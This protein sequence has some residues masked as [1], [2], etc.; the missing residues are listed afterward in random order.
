M[1]RPLRLALV[2]DYSL[3]V[4]GLKGMLEG[5]ADRIEVVEMA[6]RENAAENVDIA[7]YDT[8]GA[9]TGAGLDYESLVGNEKVGKVVAY[10]FTHD[11]RAVDDAMGAGADG[12]LSKTLTAQ[13]LVDALER[14]AAG[15][16]VVELGDAES[17]RPSGNWPGEEHGLTAREAEVLGF[18]AQGLSND[19]IAREC[20]LSINTV[21]T[22]IRSAYRKIRV[23][24]RA[25]AVAWALTHGFSPE[26]KRRKA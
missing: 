23:S 6:L 15:E 7:V 10:S 20:Y 12:Y 5:Y 9:P 13:H 22:Y 21:K 18:V 17:G 26:K 4:A 3:V 16:K 25:Q 1:T 14:V 19:E 11:Q 24:T 2:N 8:F